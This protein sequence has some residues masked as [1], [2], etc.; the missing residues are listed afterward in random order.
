MLRTTGAGDNN[1][2]AMPTSESGFGDDNVNGMP[3]SESGFGDNNVNGRPTSNATA[4]EGNVNPT[5]YINIGDDV[6]TSAATADYEDRLERQRQIVYSEIRQRNIRE[7]EHLELARR[8][9]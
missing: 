5:Q 6:N 2:S 1:V 8:Q 7:Q 3:T 4:G 9:A